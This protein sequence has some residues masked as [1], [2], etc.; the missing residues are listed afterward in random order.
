MAVVAGYATMAVVVMVG[1]IAMMATVVP[2]GLKAMR[3]M[4]DGAGAAMPAPT[5]RYLAMN[6]ALSLVAAILGGWI[7]ARIAS[8]AV[9]GHLI[10]LCVVI[11]LMS[12]VSAFASGSAPGSSLQP[13]WY[14]Y[15]IPLVGIAG[16][17]VSAL[18]TQSA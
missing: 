18:L 13:V 3:G 8:R 4:R 10:A 2:G 14:K 1:T 7:T 17:A 11:L 12:V 15:V 9:N 5:P 6:I 16:V